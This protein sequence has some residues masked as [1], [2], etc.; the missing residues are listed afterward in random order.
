[1]SKRPHE[2]GP[3]SPA[4]TATIAIPATIAIHAGGPE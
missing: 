2:F 3:K 4:A 1:M